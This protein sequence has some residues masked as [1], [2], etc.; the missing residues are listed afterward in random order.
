M[1][2][3]L[4]TEELRWGSPTAT[5][6]FEPFVQPVPELVEGAQRSFVRNERRIWKPTLNGI[7]CLTSLK[8]K[9]RNNV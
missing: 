1:W 6:P 7:S 9:R 8:R 3:C 2:V 4:K 5:P